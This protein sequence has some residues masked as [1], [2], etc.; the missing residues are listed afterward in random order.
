[1]KQFN[2]TYIILILFT[3][4]VAFI[5]DI[6]SKSL[7]EIII[8]ISGLKFLLVTL[9]FMEMKSAH[10]LWK[11]IIFCFILIFCAIVLIMK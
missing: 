5:S 11:G 7:S 3:V 9:Y 8:I 2:F 4:I 1:M 6:A 10:V